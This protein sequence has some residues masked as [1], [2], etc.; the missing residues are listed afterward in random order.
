M[1]NWWEKKKEIFRFS[2]LLCFGVSYLA[3]RDEEKFQGA[4]VTFVSFQSSQPTHFPD[5]T[6]VFFFFFSSTLLRSPWGIYYLIGNTSGK[7]N[8]GCFI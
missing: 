4:L 5:G 1:G 8:V 6:A 7:L 3:E 2:L